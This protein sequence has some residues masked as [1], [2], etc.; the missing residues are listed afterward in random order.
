MST[1]QWTCR[2]CARALRALQDPF[3]TQKRRLHDRWLQRQYA[4]ELEWKNQADE[5]RRGARK[6]MLA[7]LEERGFVNQTTGC[8]RC[9]AAR[10][11]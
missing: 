11:R 7:V 6:G 3:T 5:I 2:R 10:K 8:A 9:L 1:F 4:A